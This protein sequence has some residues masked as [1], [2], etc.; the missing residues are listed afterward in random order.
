MSVGEKRARA[1]SEHIVDDP[2]GRQDNAQMIDLT[3]N[4]PPPAKRRRQMEVAAAASTSDMDIG[5]DS[6]E[7]GEIVEQVNQ[8]V[9][10]GSSN[11]DSDSDDDVQSL[12]ARLDA[13]ISAKQ[14]TVTNISA[15][16]S[17][18][19]KSTQ[20]FLKKKVTRYY[21]EN[22][23]TVTP[24]PK[25]FACNGLGHM[26][27]ECPVARLGEQCFLCGHRGHNNESCPQRVCHKCLRE[28]H[29]ANQCT[30]RRAAKVVLCIRCGSGD[31]QVHQCAEELSRRMPGLT[32]ITCGKTGH[33]NCSAKSRKCKRICACFS[34]GSRR[35]T[36]ATCPHFEPM[37]LP[38]VLA[39]LASAY[40]RHRRPRGP[41]L[42]FNCNQPGHERR[43]CPNA[44]RRAP[45]RDYYSGGN[46]NNRG[47]NNRN[48]PSRYRRNR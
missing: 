5:S 38:T 14:A 30:S 4:S 47:F 22:S 37:D 43:D 42:C 9:R 27:D 41:K 28:G 13:E 34:C 36:V 10:K 35:H 20:V 40:N 25:C 18:P 26:R 6:D 39:G 29:S 24:L 12:L 19:K 23:S 8:A 32:C 1:E 17:P 46:R 3:V 31:H 33:A 15:R 44:L 7:E 16:A 11:S 2:Q 21:Q 45:S 48:G